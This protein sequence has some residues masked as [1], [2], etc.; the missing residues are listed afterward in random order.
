MFVYVIVDVVIDVIVVAVGEVTVFYIVA[1]VYVNA[2]N[3][4]MPLLCRLLLLVFMSP[5]SS[6]LFFVLLCTFCSCVCV[7]DSVDMLLLLFLI[8]CLC[9][10]RCCCGLSCMC[11]CNSCC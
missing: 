8:V 1:N 3:L 5:V 6:L 9:C 7:I 10:C 11:L 2:V 4:L